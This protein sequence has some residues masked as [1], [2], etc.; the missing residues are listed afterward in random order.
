MCGRYSP[1]IDYDAINDRFEFRGRA[2][3]PVQFR[4]RYN[5]AP[6]QEVLTVGNPTGEGNEPRMMRWGLIPFWAKDP[7][8]GN[9]MINARAET[10]LEKPAFRNAFSRRRCLVVA[11]GFY[12][13]RKEGKHKVPMRII[14]KTGEPFSF[15]GL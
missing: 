15:A 4:P 7:S 3:L 6:T 1:A 10:I 9:R 8:I 12:E 13:W 14:L 2:Q 11:D 5:I